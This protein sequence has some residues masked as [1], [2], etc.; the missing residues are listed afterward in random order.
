MLHNMHEATYKQGVIES[1]QKVVDEMEVVVER[2]LSA[3]IE[4]LGRKLSQFDVHFL[5]ILK[6]HLRYEQGQMSHLQKQAEYCAA[7]VQ[8]LWPAIR[9]CS[10]WIFPEGASAI[11]DL[12]MS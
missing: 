4:D 5:E 2:A 6:E 7:T 8:W 11:S 9:F 3:Q 1:T 12:P 10:L